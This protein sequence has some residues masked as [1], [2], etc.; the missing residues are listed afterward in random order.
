LL[1]IIDHGGGFMSLYG[2]N[3]ALLKEVGEYVSPGES[4]AYV[5]DSGGQANPA[6]Y[7]E[8]R[9]NGEPVNPGRWIK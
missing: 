3:Q 7:F 2:H 1:A 4:I 5:G 9:Q 6:L 8:I